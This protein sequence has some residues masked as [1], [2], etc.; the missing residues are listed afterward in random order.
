M[1][2]FGE[3]L[4]REREARGIAL[5][6][7]TDLTKI[8]SRH[9]VALESEH[10]EQLPGGV[11]NKGIVRSYARAVGLDEDVWVGR[12]VSAYQASGLVKADDAEWVQFA[13]NVVKARK[14]EG[15]RPD[16]RL[17]WAGVFLLLMLIAGLGWFVYSF[18]RDK[19]AA[20]LNRPESRQVAEGH[21]GVA[22]PS[23]CR[24]DN[25]DNCGTDRVSRRQRAPLAP[26]ISQFPHIL[27]LPTSPALPI[28]FA[29]L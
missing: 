8:G 5:D 26:R 23:A 21:P 22:R 16:L 2:H 3:E 25:S 19:G 1:A 24:T 27:S 7:I 18:V 6:S 12:Y 29:V 9:L 17:R 15:A 13:E 28:D 20:G 11:F 14:N 10:F 4:R